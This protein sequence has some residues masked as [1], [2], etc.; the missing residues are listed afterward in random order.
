MFDQIFRRP[1]TIGKHVEKK[2][3]RRNTENLCGIQRAP[4]IVLPKACA[5]IVLEN[6]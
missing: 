1:G 6:K 2:Y 5:A 3:F 4:L